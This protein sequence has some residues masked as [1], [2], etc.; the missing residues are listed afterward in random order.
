MVSGLDGFIYVHLWEQSHQQQESQGSYT[1]KDF[2]GVLNLVARFQNPIAWSSIAAYDRWL[3]DFI[4]K[5][6]TTIGIDLW[7][8]TVSAKNPGSVL[9]G[10]FWEG[11]VTSDWL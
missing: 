9:Y 11:R 4:T 6:Y 7:Y 5:Q 8:E 3:Q 10:C 1:N 2:C